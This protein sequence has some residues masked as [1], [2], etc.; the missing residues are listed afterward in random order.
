MDVLSTIIIGITSSLIAT[1]LFLSLSWYIKNIALP[2]YANK[3]YRGVRIDGRWHVECVNDLV[4]EDH[5]ATIEIN[6][7]GDSLK[8][9][10]SHGDNAGKDVSSYKVSGN[11]LNTY[12]N[13]QMWPISDKEFDSGGLLLRV[14]SD[15]GLKMKGTL[16]YISTADGS[17][18]SLEVIYAKTNS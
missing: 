5:F 17:I 2:W 13:L 3:I 1:F 9:I 10:Y 15:K 11:L 7:H 12:V 4:P 6:Q 8:G 16:S 18:K 14:Y